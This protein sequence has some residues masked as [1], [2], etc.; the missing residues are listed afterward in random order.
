MHLLRTLITFIYE[1]EIFNFEISHAS[2]R[3]P[4]RQICRI[5]LRTTG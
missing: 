1:N 2:P 4:Q 5:L 3:T